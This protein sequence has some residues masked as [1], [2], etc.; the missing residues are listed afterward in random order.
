[1]GE[2]R[3]L[4]ALHSAAMRGEDSI[5]QAL[6][7]VELQLTPRAQLSRPRSTVHETMGMEMSTTSQFC[8]VL[9][10]PSGIA[11]MSGDHTSAVQILSF[12]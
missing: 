5:V 10:R 1:M 6:L 4:G 2:S 9:A 3:R 12:S 8:A 7:N 11:A